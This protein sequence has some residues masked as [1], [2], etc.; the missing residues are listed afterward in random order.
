[1]KFITF[2]LALYVLTLSTVPCYVEDKCLN[3]D[4]SNRTNRNND[5]QGCSDCCSPFV[6]CGT[7]CGFTFHFTAFSLQA[8]FLSTEKVFSNYKQT[9]HSQFA[10][11]IW[12]PPKLG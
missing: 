6:S 5:E 3:Q 4:T 7:C 11:S 8:T 10:P 12:Q 9:F 2:I 1:M